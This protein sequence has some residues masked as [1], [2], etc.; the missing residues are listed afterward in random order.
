MDDGDRSRADA[1]KRIKNRRD[2]AMHLGAFLIVNAMM[3]GIWALSGR[4][5]FW[6]GWLMLFWAV[7]VAFHGWWALFGQPVTDQD[8]RKELDR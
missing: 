8:I 4:G 5:S 2:F 7:G 6:P 3:I 1:A